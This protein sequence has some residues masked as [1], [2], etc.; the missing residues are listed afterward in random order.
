MWRRSPMM[1]VDTPQIAEGFVA[2]L[3]GGLIGVLVGW[4]AHEAYTM[5]RHR[6]QHAEFNREIDEFAAQIR[7]LIPGEQMPAMMK[8]V[9]PL[10]SRATFRT[11]VPPLTEE[12]ALPTGTAY[13]CRYCERVVDQL[14]KAVAVI[15]S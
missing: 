7:Q 6:R 1:S 11:E 14:S 4:I 13:K 3:I 12:F 8:R 9:V 10:V 2:H 15:A 5:F